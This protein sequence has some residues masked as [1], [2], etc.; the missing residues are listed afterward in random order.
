MNLYN[1]NEKLKIIE[2]K[3]KL[4]NANRKLQNLNENYRMQM[5]NCTI[6]IKKYR[7]QM[8]VIKYK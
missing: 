2:N 1:A 5:E 3:W 8:E 7:I 4:N 6:L